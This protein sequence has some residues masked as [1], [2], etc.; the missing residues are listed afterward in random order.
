ML[1]GISTISTGKK[2]KDNIRNSQDSLRNFNRKKK[3]VV[4]Q[5]I[6]AKD[7]RNVTKPCWSIAKVIKILGKKVYLIKLYNTEIIWKR[8]LS[9]LRR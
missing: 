6:Y 8:H 4:G 2:I 1:P 5:M 3:F 7:Y 9:Q